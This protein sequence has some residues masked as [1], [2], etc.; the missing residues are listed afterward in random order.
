MS[1]STSTQPSPITA[2]DLELINSRTGLR[3][4]LREKKI[5]VKKVLR[6][7][8][9][10]ATLSELQ[11]ELVRM[12]RSVQD[13][14]RR[15]VLVFEGRDAA[16][17]GG[18]IQRFSQHLM[19]RGI[20]VVALPKPSEAERGQWYFQRYAKQLPDPGEIVFFDRSWYNR[21]VVE[22]V[23]GFCNEEQYERFMRQAPEFES[24]LH[25]SGIELVKFWFA[26]SKEEQQKRFDD[27]RGDPLK[28]W[29]ISPVDQRAQEL[30]DSYTYY[31]QEMFSRTHTAYSPWVIVQ[32]N[33]K[34]KARL[35]S[36]RYVLTHLD[37]DG[38]KSAKVNLHP[39][40]D[41]VARYHRD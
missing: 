5:D 32:A 20:R 28:N 24:M 4:L 2:E 23:N 14:G 19:P 27:R 29:K 41:I 21:A 6:T 25:D 11:T 26:I 31:S 33:S 15:V 35:E 34:K 13:Q 38:K 40:P 3:A 39:D 18:T 30:W 36:I 7:L 37:Y 1:M 22:P 9:Y 16:G 17:K 12:Q 10:E 8:R